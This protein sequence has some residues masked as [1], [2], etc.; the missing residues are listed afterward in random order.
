MR[1]IL[2]AVLG[3]AAFSLAACQSS[4]VQSA[5][6]TSGRTVEVGGGQARYNVDVNPPEPDQV[7]T[8]TT[9]AP[10]SLNGEK[11]PPRVNLPAYVRQATNGGN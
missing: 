1:A 2:L 4:S 5:D 3:S 6:A 10:Y 11:V 9:D 7:H 8:T